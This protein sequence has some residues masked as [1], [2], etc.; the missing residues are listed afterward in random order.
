MKSISSGKKHCWFPSSAKSNSGAYLSMIGLRCS[1]FARYWQWSHC[2]LL[3]EICCRCPPELQQALGLSGGHPFNGPLS[4]QLAKLDRGNRRCQQ[5]GAS[6]FT[7]IMHLGINRDSP[8]SMEQLVAVLTSLRC[9]GVGLLG[10][11]LTPA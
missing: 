1:H 4:S 7:F 3:I 9:V 2:K 11:S 5:S 10:H 6:C 8:S